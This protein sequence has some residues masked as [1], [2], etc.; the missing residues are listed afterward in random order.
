[1]GA[2][3]HLEANEIFAGAAK[4]KADM[5]NEKLNKMDVARHLLPEPAPE[6]VGELIAEL[7]RLREV[8]VTL[9]DRI[10]TGSNYCTELQQAKDF[11]QCDSVAPE[12]ELQSRRTEENEVPVSRD[13]LVPSELEQ[14][15]AESGVGIT[16]DGLPMRSARQPE[17]SPRIQ[18]II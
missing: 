17:F 16:G 10:E 3:E 15:R 13:Y 9:I 18:Q 5:N 6:V 12:M 7:R 4:R 11:L 8:L 14:F 1:M 2:L